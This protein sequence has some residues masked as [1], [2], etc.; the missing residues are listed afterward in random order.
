MVVWKNCWLGDIMRV[1]AGTAK[2]FRLSTPKGRAT[3]PTADRVKEAVFNIL[4]PRLPEAIF[5]DLF[6][7]SGAI[8]IEALSRSAQ[9]TVFVES[10]GQAVK[11]LRQNLQH[12]GF[13]EQARVLTMDGI[14]ALHL[15]AAENVSFDLAYI[16]PPY[17]QG[18]AFR[19]LACVGA[20][21]LLVPGGLALVE[22]D[23]REELAEEEGPLR[24]IRVAVYGD[25]AV[26]IYQMVRDE[27]KASNSTP[28]N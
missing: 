18:I 27:I 1:I 11:N 10:S 14:K 13:T 2:G 3:R 21:K 7:G 22:V 8:G 17:W 6:A 20:K 25:T 9:F 28:D 19:A 24:K 5:L 23:R 16:D 15:L 4:S 26:H 12:T